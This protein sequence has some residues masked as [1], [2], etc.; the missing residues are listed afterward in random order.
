VEEHDGQQS[1]RDWLAQNKGVSSQVR[2]RRN[3]PLKEVLPKVGP[4]YRQLIL[5]WASD[6]DSVVAMAGLLKSV[7]SMVR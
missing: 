5:A 6:P 3:K 4:R 1:F 2:G 7:L